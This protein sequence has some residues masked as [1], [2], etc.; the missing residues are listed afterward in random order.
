VTTASGTPQA[1]IFC[2]TTSSGAATVEVPTLV[3][4]AVKHGA[5]ETDL[6]FAPGVI[7]ISTKYARRVPLGKV[8]AVKSLPKRPVIE[9]LVHAPASLQS[10]TAVPASPPG[11]QSRS[12]LP[13]RS[14][15]GETPVRPSDTASS[16]RA[17]STTA[18]A[19]GTC[20]KPATSENPSAVARSDFLMRMVILQKLQYAVEHILVV[21][22]DYENRCTAL[23]TGHK[24]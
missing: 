9:T 14:T 7:E 3:H 6:V 12:A 11:Y 18:L 4:A 24:Y 20:A 8:I 22:F 17:H 15:C 1:F 21:L 2:E 10:A 23:A 19:V 13:V 16:V 5:D